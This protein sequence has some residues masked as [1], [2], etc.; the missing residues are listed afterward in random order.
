M[1]LELNNVNS[2]CELE[3]V[4]KEKGLKPVTPE[5]SFK[6]LLNSTR[7][8]WSNGQGMIISLFTKDEEDVCV[9]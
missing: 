2:R 6:L 5:D 1:L 7:V 8:F 9:N 4:L 3:Q